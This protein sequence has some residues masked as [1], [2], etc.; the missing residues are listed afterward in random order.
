VEPQH[1]D[2]PHLPPPTLWPVGFA[3]GVACILVGLIVNPL[4]IV[5]IGVVITVVFGILW[6][7]EATADYR[8]AT[9]PEVEPEARPARRPAPAIPASEGEAGMPPP[10]PGERFPRNKFLELATLGL[11]GV[12][13]G[14]V[15][16]PILGPLLWNPYRRPKKPAVDIGPLTNFPVGKYVVTTYSED[17]AEGEVTRRTAYVR[18]NGTFDGLPSITIISN[19]CAHLGCPVQ[20][21]GP[22]FENAKKVEKTQTGGAVRL[23][24]ALP[25]GGFGCPCHG[26]QYDQEGNRTAGPPVRALDRFSY[27]VVNGHVILGKRYAVSHVDGTGADAKVHKYGAAGPGEHVDGPEAWLYPLNPPEPK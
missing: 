22:V 4:V 12:I 26:G 24:P 7:R 14:L 11:G 23:V 9:V 25:A 20:P 27:A 10:E 13:G 19:R 18:N 21:N 15:T 3:V 16:I 1:G 5:P 8:S 17:P 6:A 2:E